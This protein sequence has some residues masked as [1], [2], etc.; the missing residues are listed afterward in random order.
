MTGLS[1]ESTEPLLPGVSLPSDTR[2]SYQESRL[3]KLYQTLLSRPSVSIER[4]D[5]H[6]PE[7]PSSFFKDKVKE[8]KRY[9]IFTAACHEIVN[10]IYAARFT[11]LSGG[12]GVPK[13][14][15]VFH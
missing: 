5:G 14:Q 13:P 3:G 1:Q 11:M 2:A 10:V 15:T 7:K 6:L 8:K 12:L 4:G 9:S